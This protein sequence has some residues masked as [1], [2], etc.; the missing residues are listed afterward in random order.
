M[1]QDLGESS[2]YDEKVANFPNQTTKVKCTHQRV[3]IKITR[4]L[5]SRNQD[6]MKQI[7]RQDSRI[8]MYGNLN[9]S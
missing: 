5:S 7:W 8:P 1:L 2:I 9:R 4:K 3:T 6:S